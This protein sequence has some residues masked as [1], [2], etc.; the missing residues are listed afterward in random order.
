M[1]KVTLFYYIFSFILLVAFIVLMISAY[2]NLSDTVAS[3]SQN[4][5][6]PIFVIDAGH[7]GEDGGAVANEITEKD[8]NLKIAQI[9]SDII[10]SNGYEVVMTR[11]DDNS[12][13]SSGDT[14]RERKVSDMKNRL[15]I[16]NSDP[17][18]IVISIHQ[19]KFTESQYSGTQIFYSPNNE[20]SSVLA[21]SIRKSVVNLLQPDNE[22]QSKAAGNE[23][24]LLYNSKAPSVIVE[25]GFISNAEEA[26][27]LQNEDYQKQIAWSIFLGALDF[28]NNSV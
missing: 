7:G 28:A 4:S 23:I 25:C 16:F 27:K 3:V 17:D 13:E 6:K 18:N 2:S 9:L 12:I 15:E 10:A 1:K 5:S 24:Y 8:I 21:E 11:N 14:L 22:R 19:N 20:K 26:E